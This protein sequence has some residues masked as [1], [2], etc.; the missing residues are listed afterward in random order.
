MG[1]LGK[2][3]GVGWHFL[4]Q[5]VFLTQGLKLCLLHWRADSLPLSHQGSPITEYHSAW[6]KKEILSFVT[7]QMKLKDMLSGM[8]QD[9]EKQILHDLT[10][11]IY[12]SQFIGAECR[13][14]NCQGLEEMQRCGS[15]DTRFQLHRA[16]KFWGPWL[17]KLSCTLDIY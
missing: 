16:G 13:T 15:K 12:K 6:K 14:S 7:I 5:G 10:C 3:N 9:T 2:D 4:L 8:G 11:G 17:L 1:S